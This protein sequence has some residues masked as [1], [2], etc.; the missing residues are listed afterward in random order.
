MTV[1]LTPGLSQWAR[2]TGSALGATFIVRILGDTKR[3]L[4]ASA[5][6]M[7]GS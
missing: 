6:E 7:L 1:S 3:L 4:L 2:V 5:T